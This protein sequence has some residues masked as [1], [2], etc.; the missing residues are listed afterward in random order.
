MATSFASTP[1]NRDFVAHA[2]AAPFVSSA[3]FAHQQESIIAFSFSFG[4]R[5]GEQL[6]VQISPFHQD[7]TS[8][9]KVLSS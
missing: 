8:V 4:A 3:F 7:F 1:A 6:F 9:S 2:P 5:K